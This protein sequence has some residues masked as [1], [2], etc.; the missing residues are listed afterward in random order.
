MTR[1]FRIQDDLDAG[2][3][4]TIRVLFEELAA[5]N[6]DVALD[7]SNVSFIDSSGVGGL[8]F[9]YKRLNAKGFRLELSGLA[10]QPRQLLDHLKLTPILVPQP[11]ERAG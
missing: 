1:K 10:G 7:V 9:L 6:D 4:A 11:M 5:A 8:V 3:M 2:G